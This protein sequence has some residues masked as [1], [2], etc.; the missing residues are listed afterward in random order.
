LSKSPQNQKSNRPTPTKTQP[1][2]KRNRATSAMNPAKKPVGKI[3]KNK[4]KFY[5]LYKQAQTTKRLSPGNA[6]I[7][8][9]SNVVSSVWDKIKSAI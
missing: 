2:I 3:A 4:E 7:T 9:S 6:R 1:A 5:Q 8:V